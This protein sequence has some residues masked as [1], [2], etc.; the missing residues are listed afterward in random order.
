MPPAIQP[1]HTLKPTIKLFM[2]F[3]R[4]FHHTMPYWEGKETL[5]LRLAMLESQLED[6]AYKHN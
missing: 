6:K 1:A 3:G 2:T 4:L 5:W